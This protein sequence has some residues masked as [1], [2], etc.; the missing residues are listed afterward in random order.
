MSDAENRG[1][2]GLNQVGVGR[3]DRQ[4]GRSS[5]Y[6]G[7]KQPKIA[8]L[9]ARKWALS[10]LTTAG[11]DEDESLDNIDFLLTGALKINYGMLRANLTRVMPEWLAERW[12][13]Y[14]AGLLKGRP[15]Q[16]VIGEAPFY[17]R[18]FLVDERVL[19]PRPETELL[20]DWVLSDLK[21]EPVLAEGPRLLDVGTG[22]GAIALTLADEMPVLKATA[23][24]ISREALAVAW[25]NRKK[26]GLV[27]RVDLIESDLF[28]AFS[29]Q[30]FD[31]IVSNPPY[32]K[33]DGQDEM[34]ESVVAFE[35]DLALYAD[36]QGLALYEEMAEHLAEH[37]TK[38]G[39]AY[40]EIGYDQGQAL[41][42]IFKQALPDA[43]VTL[44]QD[45]AGLDRMIRVKI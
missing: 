25:E 14:I 35:P 37:L 34:D 26:L 19:I 41:V 1:L 11:F 12:P 23:A 40:F 18:D 9:E 17:G 38:H 44:K 7:S 39:R 22:S 10:E 13:N 32:I 3:F 29:D 8:L 36:H 33:R 15:A 30:R 45:L 16:Y 24:D 31:V 42:T 43:E 27:D 28:L 2:P 6:S 5:T 20:V 21:K 4:V